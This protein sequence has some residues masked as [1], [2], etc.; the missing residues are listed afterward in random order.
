MTQFKKK[1]SACII[2]TT[3]G[4]TEGQNSAVAD[5]FPLMGNKHVENISI[6]FW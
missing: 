3:S 5:I 1:K 6:T 4:T 2:M